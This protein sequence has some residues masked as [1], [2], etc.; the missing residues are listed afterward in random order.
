MKVSDVVT[1]KVIS[2]EPQAGVLEAVRL[3]LQNHISGLP[4][5]DAGGKLVGMVTE[6][7]LLR[8]AETGTQRRRSRWLEFLVG[9]GKLAGEYVHT[10][11]RRVD[12]VMTSEPVT[13]GEDAELDEVVRLM[14]G[15]GIKRLPVVRGG[16]VVGIISR[17][18][19]LHA[20]ASVGKVAPAAAATDGAIRDRILSEIDRQKWAAPGVF[21]V[22]VHNGKAE[23]WGTVIDENQRQAIT[24]LVENIPGVKSIADHLAWIEPMSGMTIEAPLR[25]PVPVRGI[26]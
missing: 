14:E 25:G 4:V 6:G 15:R 26:A 8:R 24:V 13:V 21:N 10:H 22:T 20:L 3:M 16:R 18:N 19:L 12:E 17:A 9:P 2:I 7:D 11:A 1:R 5:I 23:L